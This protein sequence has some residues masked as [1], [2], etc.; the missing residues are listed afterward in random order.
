MEIGDV[1]PFPIK[2]KTRDKPLISQKLKGNIGDV[3]AVEKV[4]Y[5]WYICY[6]LWGLTSSMEAQF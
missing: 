1:Y 5:F 3:G 4:P 2:E 6:Q